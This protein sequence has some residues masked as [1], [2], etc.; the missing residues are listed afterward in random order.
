MLRRPRFDT[1]QPDPTVTAAM[2]RQYG[3]PG[4]TRVRFI[5]PPREE[6][7]MNDDAN[8]RRP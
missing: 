8:W 4:S 2:W 7:D 1:G 5:A 6:H 3:H